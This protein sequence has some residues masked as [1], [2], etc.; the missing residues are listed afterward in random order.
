MC[1][2]QENVTISAESMQYLQREEKRGERTVNNKVVK[3][4]DVLYSLHKCNCHD[5]IPRGW[6]D[7][8]FQNCCDKCPEACSFVCL[9]YIISVDGYHCVTIKE[10]CQKSRH[11]GLIL[12]GKE[13]C[14][15]S[16]SIL[17]VARQSCSWSCRLEAIWKRAVSEQ[18]I[19]QVEKY[20]HFMEAVALCNEI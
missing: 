10:M 7:K 6:Q 18:I 3:T 15:L 17:N 12:P 11:L 13:G 2:H 16:Y 4:G 8:M 9:T 5:L 1:L 20:S 14:L 19:N